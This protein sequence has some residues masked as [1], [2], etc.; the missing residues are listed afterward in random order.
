MSTS[1]AMAMLGR[2]KRG[3]GHKTTQYGTP[4]SFNA[5]TQMRFLGNFPPTSDPS[6]G[7][8]EGVVLDD[9]CNG[10]TKCYLGPK[11]LRDLASACVEVA[12]WLETRA[13]K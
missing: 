13:S 9:D 7:Q 1:E 11:D 10:G 2:L 4:W 5:R 12:D 3:A 8:L 6:R